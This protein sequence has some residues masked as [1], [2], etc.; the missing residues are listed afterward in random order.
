ME[1]Y[2]Q[3]IE[4]KFV[5]ATETNKIEEHHSWEPNEDAFVFNSKI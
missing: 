4:I 5:Y 3:D 1:G 2:D